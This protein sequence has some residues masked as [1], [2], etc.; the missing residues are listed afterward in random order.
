MRV[1]QVCEVASLVLRALQLPIF[2]A[3]WLWTVELNKFLSS[4][5]GSSLGSFECCPLFIRRH[6][7]V[8]WQAVRNNRA[9][10]ASFCF[11][12]SIEQLVLFEYTNS[13]LIMNLK[14][15]CYLNE[16]RRPQ[17][18]RLQRV[19]YVLIIVPVTDWT[20]HVEQ[21]ELVIYSLHYILCLTYK[22]YQEA[23]TWVKKFLPNNI[24]T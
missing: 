11:Y 14:T 20:S 9:T 5:E 19:I 17:V 7:I 13:P 4:S 22:N 12:H 10:A 2:R 18:Y 8:V 24:F 16:P 15:C 3:T 1:L 21:Q 23:I 6:I